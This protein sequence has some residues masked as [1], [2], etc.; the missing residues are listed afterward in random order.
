MCLMQKN[1]LERRAQVVIFNCSEVVWR[2]DVDDTLSARLI[3][4]NDRGRSQMCANLVKA[5]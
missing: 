1:R 2:G 5:P 4:A 3:G